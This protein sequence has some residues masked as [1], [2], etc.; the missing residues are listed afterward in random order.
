MTEDTTKT[1]TLIAPNRPWL[2]LPVR[3]LWAYR[4]LIWLLVRRDLTSRFKQNILGPA[5]FFITP[6]VMTLVMNLVFN[7]IAKVSTDELP[8]PL[9][10]MSGLFAW[11]LVNATFQGVAETFRGNTNLFG[12]V[13]FPRLCVPIAQAFTSLVNSGVQL[14]SFLVLFLYFYFITDARGIGPSLSLLW[15]LPAVL[16][17]LILG[18]GAGLIFTSVT[19]K[20][21][22]LA[23]TLPFISQVWLYLSAV[24][25]PVSS[26][27]TALAEVAALNPAIGI[28]ALARSALLAQPLPAAPYLISA[29]AIPLA[30]L[31]VGMLLFNRTERTFLDTV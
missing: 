8:G 18:V 30:L 2:Q 31:I 11:N 10:Y 20:Y 24:V 23:Q 4:D 26:I 15:L 16:L 6:L 1:T 27:P 22:D 19:A 21:R 5:W 17:T 3:E 14:I 7:R 13:Y 28:V 9:F 25:F 12:K 29:V